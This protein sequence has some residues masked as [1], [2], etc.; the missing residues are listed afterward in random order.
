MLCV[1]D[2]GVASRDG[3][4]GKAAAAAPATIVPMRRAGGRSVKGRQGP[5]VGVAPKRT[6][7]LNAVEIVE[8]WD[9]LCDACTVKHNLRTSAERS[10]VRDAVAQA[11]CEA[12]PGVEDVPVAPPQAFA[13]VQQA[14]AASRTTLCVLSPYPQ[15]LTRAVLSRCGYDAD[16]L[17]VASVSGVGTA[18]DLAAPRTDGV[19]PHIH[20]V[21]D[22]YSALR[23]IKGRLLGKG[24]TDA[25][26]HSLQSQWVGSDAD[27][28]IGHPQP[29]VK[30]HMCDWALRSPAMRAQASGDAAMHVLTDVGL[31][32]LLGVQDV[33]AVMD[34]VSWR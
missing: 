18:Q 5:I 4:F 2:Q 22:S 6:R 33:D 25:F 31:A 13:S 19:P 23:R 30:L 1:L 27:G 20:V 32:D 10:A 29:A 16:H 34:G 15:P 28:Q 26:R 17:H 11:L 12:L 21:M 14:F 7:P 3:V 24:G 8:N 9:I